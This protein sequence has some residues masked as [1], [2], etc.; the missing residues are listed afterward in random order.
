[1]RHD[2]V[3]K[4]GETLDSSHRVTRPPE[5]ICQDR[6]GLQSLAFEHRPVGHTGRTT[7]PSIADTG[8]DDVRVL[9]DLV[10][11]LVRSWFG[12][13]GLAAYED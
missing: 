1:M 12:E 11:E 13:A 4:V 9:D 7:G 3:A 8:E 5:R 6:R 10:D 2:R